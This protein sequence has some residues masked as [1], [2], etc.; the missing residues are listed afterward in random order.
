MTNR[1]R[2]IAIDLFC[3]AGGMSLGF[4]QAGFDVVLAVDADKI[5]SKIHEE[6]FPD[7]LTVCSDLK[8]VSGD[9]L[10][11]AA[12]LGRKRIDV[13]FGGPPCQGFSAGGKNR[14][15]DERNHLLL[16]FAR[17]VGELQPRYFVMENVDQLL[18][19]HN[20]R[21]L[22]R[23]T[24][25]IKRCGY[26]IV[27]DVQILNAADF[28]VPQR[29]RRAFLMGARAGLQLPT[30]PEPS[31]FSSRPRPTVWD[32]IR[33]LPNI[34]RYESL[35]ESDVFVGRLKKPSAYA[36]ALRGDTK[37][38]TDLSRKRRGIL[39]GLSGC[40]R[41]LHSNAVIRRFAATGPGDQEP[42]SR[43]FRLDPKSVS[44]TIRAG[45]GTD[46]GS[47]TAPRPIHPH[48][49]RC[50]TVREAARLHSFPDWFQFHPTKWHGFRQVGN[51]VPPLLA[52][53][54]A[55][56]IATLL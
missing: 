12:K 41:T 55:R 35:L 32:A 4:E 18:S 36:A 26:S 17:L 54:V 14:P 45:T 19:P 21:P 10:K 6:N 33:D 5:H 38:S 37:S 31:W 3:G 29:R 28:G 24:R 53:A 16:E 44:M 52:R 30:Y 51:S 56:R 39:E 8:R 46:R 48:E 43:F 7:G 2:P 49:A 25:K 9:T 23:F 1:S 13:V 11:K 40:R 42:I 47:F 34:E 20:R 22:E 27:E 50:I 15:D